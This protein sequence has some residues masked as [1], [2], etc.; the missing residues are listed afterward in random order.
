M[1]GTTTIGR[2]TW[3]CHSVA[4]RSLETEPSGAKTAV[5]IR[6]VPVIRSPS[7]SAVENPVVLTFWH[8]RGERTSVTNNVSFSC[9]SARSPHVRESKTVLDSGFHAVNSGFQVLDSS[10][11]Q[12]NLDSGFKSLEGYTDSK[13]QDCGIRKQFS[14]FWIP[15]AKIYWIP[16]SAFPYTGRARGK[17]G[18]IFMF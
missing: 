2:W 4:G 5:T 7:G 8:K 1:R 6:V 17:R 12:W 9:T 18:E 11:C 3:C 16:E 13:A 15:P 14:R 10:L